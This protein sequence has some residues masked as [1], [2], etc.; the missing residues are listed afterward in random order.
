M[1]SSPAQTPCRAVVGELIHLSDRMKRAV[2]TR[3]VISMI[4]SCEG[5]ERTVSGGGDDR[6][7]TEHRGQVGL[8]FSR[9]QDCADHGN[10]IERVGQG[11][12]RRV[13]ERRYSA[14]YLETNKARQ[15]EYV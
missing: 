10:G 4:M 6:D 14:D 3:H 2:A 7:G 13:Q 1:P 8:V 12:Q 11:H 5:K 9:Q 15:H